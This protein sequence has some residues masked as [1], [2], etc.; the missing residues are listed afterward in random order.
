MDPIYDCTQ[1]IGF[2][3]VQGNQESFRLYMDHTTSPI[4]STD[5][6]VLASIRD[7]NMTA[8]VHKDRK[9]SQKVNSCQEIGSDA[10]LA[11]RWATLLYGFRSDKKLF[12]FVTCSGHM[13]AKYLFSIVLESFHWTLWMVIYSCLFF[14]VTYIALNSD[15]W[16]LY[17][18]AQTSISI[19]LGIL[20]SEIF[21]TNVLKKSNMFFHILEL[22]WHFDWEFVS[23]SA[24]RIFGYVTKI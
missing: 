9:N 15:S 14:L 11:Y 16:N 2:D 18:N 12:S 5:N 6:L 19:A 8:I 13:K 4:I 3:N 7:A 24:N 10:I 20:G 1:D 22:H 21:I 17:G 23:S